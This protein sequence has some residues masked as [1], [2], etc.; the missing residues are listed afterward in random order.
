[1][2]DLLLVM[3]DSVSLL[4]VFPFSFLSPRFSSP[5]FTAFSFSTPVARA[6]HPPCGSRGSPESTAPTPPGCETDPAEASR[7]QARDLG[8]SRTLLPSPRGCKRLFEGKAC[9]PWQHLVLQPDLPLTPPLQGSPQAPSGNE[10]LVK[11][12]P[13]A[14][15]FPFSVRG[16]LR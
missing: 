13:R 3:S 12:R 4:Y 1:M 16:Y 6:A 5:L 7:R 11:K 14:P 9:L 8:I 10:T 2:W 15:L